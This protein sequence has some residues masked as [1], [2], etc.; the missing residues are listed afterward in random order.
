[1]PDAIAVLFPP[2]LLRFDRL[3]YLTSTLRDG[4]IK[5]HAALTMPEADWLDM[6]SG[7]KGWW[8]KRAR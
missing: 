5:W 2:W 7:Y 8:A 6:Y 3:Q 4:S 1:M